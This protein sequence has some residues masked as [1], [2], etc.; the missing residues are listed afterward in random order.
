LKEAA[1][2]FVH[3]TTSTQMIVVPRAFV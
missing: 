3:V 2:A 1:L